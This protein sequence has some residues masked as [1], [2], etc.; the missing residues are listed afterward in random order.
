MKGESGRKK[1]RK[2]KRKIR[3]ESCETVEGF[4]ALLG[5]CETESLEVVK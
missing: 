3:F 2:T 4:E 1:L 5:M